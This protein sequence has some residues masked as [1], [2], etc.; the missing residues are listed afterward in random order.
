M[1]LRFFALAALAALA[2]APPAPAALV[3]EYI[4]IPPGGDTSSGPVNAPALAGP[5]VLNPGQTVFLQIALRDTTGNTLPWNTN[6]GN[7][8]P[9]SLGLGAFFIQFDSIPGVA[10]NPGLSLPTNVRLVDQINYGPTAA[11]TSPPVFTRFGGLLNFGSEPGAVPDPADFDRIP[12]FNLRIQAIGAGNGSFQL[13]DPNPSPTTADNAV[14]VDSDPFGTPNPGT[15]V[16]I[17]DLLFGVGSTN[18]YSLPVVVTPEPTSLA[19]AGLAVAGLGV[20]RW[21]RRSSV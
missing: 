1:R 13:G 21:R 7:A 16:S 19:L 10:V 3:L 4:M 18:R 9:G 20:R 17:D 11:G 8:G 5:L 2:L 14:L 15:F 6:G 12:L